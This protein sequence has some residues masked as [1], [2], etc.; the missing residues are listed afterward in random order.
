MSP[1]HPRIILMTTD[2][3]G[4]V[5]TYSTALARALCGYGHKVVL[6][7]M[8]PPPRREQLEALM[9]IAGLT[10]EPTGLALEWMDP[11]GADVAHARDTLLRLC[12]R[13]KPDLVHLNSF[14]EATFGFDAPTV[15]V[16]HS[17]VG[18][19]W[20]ACRPGLPIERKWRPYLRNVARG[21]DA[22]GVWVAPTHTYRDWVMEA[23]KPRQPNA[24]IWN[25]T[26]LP[27]SA[28]PKQ[29]FIL[30]AG[31]LWDEAKKLAA[32]ADIADQIAWPVRIA[33][34]TVSPDG[35][36]GDLPAGVAWLGALPHAALIAQMREAAILAAPALYEPFGLTV[37][38]AANCGCALVLSDIPTFGELWDGA[39]AFADPRDPQALIAA[40]DALCH[41][42][43]L[44]ER[45]RRTA[46]QRARRYTLARMVDA[47]RCLYTRL[48]QVAERA[49]FTPILADAT[50]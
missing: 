49:A 45:M 32:L 9:D 24:V 34:P 12:E 43:S 11:E 25:G 37:L 39:A 26:A 36:A 22:A 17:C 14:R 42:E 33:G 47:Y 2:A 16:A 10:F 30:A 29:P 48:T 31:R 21:L 20:E 23:Y 4:G 50:L 13:V 15:V 40:L 46:A 6:V 38:E 44:R 18:S 35:G 7:G 41:D 5:W 3:V 1:P 8:G 28:A 19:W 27:P